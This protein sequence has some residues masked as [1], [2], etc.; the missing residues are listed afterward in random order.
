VEIIGK[1]YRNF[2]QVILDFFTIKG[3]I[4]YFKVWLKN[5]SIIR[6]KF[7]GIFQGVMYEEL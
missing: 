1:N 7:Q 4:F 5:R 3:I 2:I 6:L